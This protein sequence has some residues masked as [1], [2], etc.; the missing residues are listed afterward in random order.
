VYPGFIPSDD[1]VKGTDHG[2]TPFH[3]IGTS[4]HSLLLNL[5]LAFVEPS[6]HTTSCIPECPE[7]FSKH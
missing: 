2:L 1:A 3:K 7:L 6:W 5:S 4:L